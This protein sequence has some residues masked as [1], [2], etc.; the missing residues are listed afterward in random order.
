MTFEAELVMFVC[1][2]GLFVAVSCGKIFIDRYTLEFDRKLGN[3]STSF[4][5]VNNVSCTNLTIQ[6]FQTITKFVAYVKVNLAENENDREYKREFVRTVVDVAKATAGEQMN[7]LVKGFFE[8]LKPY[9]DFKFQM[10]MPP[11]SASFS[12]QNLIL[13]LFR[14]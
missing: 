8:N 11:V 14:E 5:N 12:F 4:I 1:F 7:F 13:I 10:P 3:W 6:P 2:S 9:M